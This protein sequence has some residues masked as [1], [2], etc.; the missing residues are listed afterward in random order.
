V[1][2]PI[3]VTVLLVC[4]SVVITSVWIIRC[5]HTQAQP[6]PSADDPSAILDEANRLSWLGNWYAS[7]P[8]F[9]IAETR[10]QLAGDRK[11]ESY[12]RIGLIRS[13]AVNTRLDR[14]L[15]TLTSELNSI[16]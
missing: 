4:L 9:E 12:A 1:K 7:A 13:Q 6:K 16:D 11:D 3:R 2:S 8:L 15:A 5:G 14:T 10:F